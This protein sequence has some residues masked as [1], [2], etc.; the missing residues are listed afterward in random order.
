LTPSLLPALALLGCGQPE[1]TEAPPAEAPAAE[2]PAP[3]PAPA[4][5]LPPLD[6]LPD[7]L[8]ITLDTTRA[9][10]LGSYGYDKALTDTLDGLAASGTRF[11]RAY[12]PL[13][14]TIPS[15]ATLFTG[16]YPPEHGIRS[17]G[18]AVLEADEVTLAERLKSAGYRTAAS[19]A[20]FVTTRRFGFDQGFD[21]YYDDV[22]TSEDF[23][24]AE[25]PADAV[26]DDMLRWEELHDDGERPRFAWVHLYDA[27]FPYVPWPE[28]MKKT[29]GRPYDA[30][31][32]RLDD[33]IDR[34]VA[35]F[36]ERPTLVVVVGDH[37][38]GLGDHHE[39]AH[40]L[41]VY[42]STQRVPF[43]LTGPGVEA[44]KVEPKPVSLADVGPTILD[45]L[46]L[47]PLDGVSGRSVYDEGSWPVYMESYQVAERFQ[48]APPV[49]VV[50][51][52]LKLI[53]LPT[54]ELY[55]V[56]A[57]P[58]EST[59]LAE[60]RPDDVKRLREQLV[61]WAFP[62]PSVDAAH[63]P[64]AEVAA[65]LAALGYTSGG[66]FDPDA[67]LPDPKEHVQM[68][69]EGQLADRAL[70]LGKTDEAIEL[71]EKLTREYPDIS[72]FWGRLIQVY[73]RA[74]RNEEARQRVDEALARAPDSVQLLTI[75]ANHLAQ[76][77][78]FLEASDLYRRVAAEMPYS[79]RIRTMAVAMLYQAGKPDEGQE[80][81]LEYLEDYPDDY[82]LA[83]FIGVDYVR[84]GKFAQG[85][86]YLERGILAD[87]PERD[88]AFHLAAAA[89]GRRQI[90]EAITLLQKE[91]DAYPESVKAVAALG[92]H[93]LGKQRNDDVLDLTEDA[94]SRLEKQPVVWYLKAQA[95]FNL[96]RYEE[97]RTA[98]EKGLEVSDPDL[99][100]LLMLEANLLKQE[101][102]P[103]LAQARYEEALKAREAE[104]A[105]QRQG[106]PRPGMPPRR[107]PPQR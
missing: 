68:L 105:A 78:A 28:Y 63:A 92:K 40:G 10:R 30:E 19:V 25:R 79:P 76:A 29:E 81:A 85:L 72:E 97:A 16:L 32:A 67:K 93:L 83:G 4:A 36:D 21:V 59:N 104:T 89:S 90:D 73:E 70:M 56:V 66:S 100:D 107:G 35:A 42:D 45:L 52:S 47:P 57:D 15:H 14:L 65:Q 9:D 39:V 91:V 53:D 38:E 11:D 37:G 71:L 99:S 106:G 26:I 84:R 23:W 5:E 75:K 20:A 54:P 103:D 101:G 50:E 22:K 51:G 27:H 24:H 2:A 74:G 44:G 94:L 12:S 58:A 88:V 34:L 95:L 80:L 49:A 8:L 96:K 33:Q 13:P 55:D 69:R 102:K 62:A 43:F 7:V 17:N 60:Q 18:D 31:L 77:G 41:H 82:S 1:S 61:T 86:T 46:G 87:T 98:L 48:L 6:E 3:T 64:N